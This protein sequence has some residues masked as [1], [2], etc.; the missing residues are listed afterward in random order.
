[1]TLFALGLTLI[2]LY[3]IFFLRATSY[4]L[5]TNFS[6]LHLVLALVHVAIMINPHLI[7]HTPH[8]L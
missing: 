4:D 5:G 6:I 8:Y 1:M 2:F 3:F 7:N